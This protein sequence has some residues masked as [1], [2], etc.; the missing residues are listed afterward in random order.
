MF[1]WDIVNIIHAMTQSSLR[2]SVQ[3]K[4]SLI[5]FWDLHDTFQTFHWRETNPYYICNI[6]INSI[7]EILTQANDF[8]SLSAR[9]R[10]L[11]ENFSHDEYDLPDFRSLSLYLTMR[12]SEQYME[13]LTLLLLVCLSHDTELT[14]DVDIFFLWGKMRDC[15]KFICSILLTVF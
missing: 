2:V 8:Y 5:Y 12:C 13:A 10:G 6:K 9:E 4:E 3:T 7:Y 15:E 14:D 11:G 1:I